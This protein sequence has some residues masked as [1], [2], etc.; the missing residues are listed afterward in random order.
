MRLF[1]QNNATHP[2]LKLLVKGMYLYLK[3]ASCVQSTCE[4]ARAM[5]INVT[6]I[7]YCI[8]A[9]FNLQRQSSLKDASDGGVHHTCVAQL[10]QHRTRVRTILW[11]SRQVCTRCHM[12]SVPWPDGSRAQG[13]NKLL[14]RPRSRW[15][16]LRLRKFPGATSHYLWLPSRQESRGNHTG[17]AKNWTP[18]SKVPVA[19][20]VGG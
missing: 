18:S 14:C 20:I 19:T 17:Y 15:V 5:N 13:S 7:A 6:K 10:S 2:P 4:H 11:A 8:T 3:F 1:V 12:A 16:G 9:N